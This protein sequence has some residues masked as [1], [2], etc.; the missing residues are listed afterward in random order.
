MKKYSQRDNIT[1]NIVLK[2]LWLLFG[3]VLLP[4]VFVVPSLVYDILVVAIGGFLVFITV[5][6]YKQGE[7]LWKHAYQEWIKTISENNENVKL[8]IDEY[9]A[10]L[11]EDIKRAKIEE[12]REF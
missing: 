5:R 1:L 7:I 4:I 8:W 11:D 12:E 10:V 2:I 9:V 6:T 3:F